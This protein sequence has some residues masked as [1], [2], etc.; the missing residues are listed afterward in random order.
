MQG[1]TSKNPLTFLLAMSLG[2]GLMATVPSANA[3]DDAAACEGDVLDAVAIEKTGGVFV[4]E[5]N[6]PSEAVQKGYS[7]DGVTVIVDGIVMKL[8][9]AFVKGQLAVGAF[10]RVYAGTTIPIPPGELPGWL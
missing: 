2:A 7:D 9:P 5:S 6:L 8:N 10:I 1:V 3:A 4:L